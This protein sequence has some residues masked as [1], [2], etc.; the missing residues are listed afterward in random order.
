MILYNSAKTPIML[1]F[2]VVRVFQAK[3]D[4]VTQIKN[5]INFIELQ[6]CTNLLYI[7][8]YRTELYIPYI[9]S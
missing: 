9:K 3:I 5:G 6:Y 4:E 2:Y 8:I 1:R 7:L